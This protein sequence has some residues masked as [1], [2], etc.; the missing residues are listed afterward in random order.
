MPLSRPHRLFPPPP[1]LTQ[2]ATSTPKNLTGVP[3][4][5]GAVAGG[6]TGSQPSG[7]AGAANGGGATGGGA[8]A[9]TPGGGQGGGQAA[10]GGS[11]TAGGGTGVPAP[12]ATTDVGD[13]EEDV[14]PERQA[15][16]Q[17]QDAN[18]C[19]VLWVKV[20]TGLSA[21]TELL[22]PGFP[23]TP[24][25]ASPPPPHLYALWLHRLRRFDGGEGQRTL[26][27]TDVTKA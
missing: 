19:P 9:P 5:E 15:A 14:D 27:H 26:C 12:L 17:A 18:P 20:G 1:P 11:L 13:E 3:K 24:S 22:F 2:P 7:A 4:P 16:Y 8:A 21:A 6:N 10:G 23:N 25:P